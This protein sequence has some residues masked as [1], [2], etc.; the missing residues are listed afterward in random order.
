VEL[1]E[2]PLREVPPRILPRRQRLGQAIK[3]IYPSCRLNFRMHGVGS[4]SSKS[5]V[6]CKAARTVVTHAIQTSMAGRWQ[7]LRVSWH[8]A[9]VTSQDLLSHIRKYVHDNCR[10]IVC[11][12]A[13][14]RT[15]E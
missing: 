8:P 13:K 12:T 4:F 15:V 9:L 7:S 1:Q 10:L 14:D 3:Y 5:A 11:N 2:T 6:F